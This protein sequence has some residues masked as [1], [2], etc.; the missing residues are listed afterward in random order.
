MDQGSKLDVDL[1]L[2][3]K[4]NMPGPRYTSYPTAPH[5]HDQFTHA[6]FEQEIITTNQ[7]EG[8]QPNLSLYFHLP[9]CDS[10]CFFC[11]CNVVI[12]HSRE[13]I[14]EYV[15]YL[16]KEIDLVSRHI[17]PS[18]KVVQLH[19]G[20]GTPTYLTP[21]QI[22][23]V[24]GHIKQRFNFAET[25]EISI[26]IDPRSVTPEHL[27]ALKDVG[28]NRLSF[29][30]QDV[31]DKVQKAVNR[32]QPEAMTRGVVEESRK[33]GFQS[34]NIDLMYGLPHQTIET[35]VDTLE[36]A[37]DISPDRLA[38]FNYAHVP[39]LK[40]HQNVLPAE[41]LPGATER[42]NI[43]KLVIERLTES[44]Y[45]YI[46][47]DHFA[48]PEDE[49]SL[50]LKNHTLY[51]NFQG[52]STS[53]DAE[54]YAM[55]STSISQ[56]NNV[57]A[58]NKKNLKEYY[59]RLDDGQLPTS[60]GYRLSDDDQV[61]RYVITEVM[62]NNRVLK[63]E[64]QRRFGVEFDT[65]FS[66]AL[67]KMKPFVDE[68]LVSLEPDRLQIHEAGRLIIRNIAMAFD[69]YLEA[70]QQKKEPMYSRTV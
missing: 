5:F 30:V 52:Y 1:A 58:Q 42:L 16:K 55:G 26:E 17:N 46:G 45:V 10:L 33:L 65:Y 47:M 69:A 31:D 22:R 2:L 9:F 34:I 62:C 29:G 25:A 44:G 18:R 13:R 11:A 68:K 37:I 24:F 7:S 36:T 50:A 61:R 3:Q 40:K 23:E 27:P 41:A 14:Q 39:W 4:Y 64:V 56:L 60:V 12:T 35:Y 43:L 32:I 57:Y 8:E 70:D 48:K 6:D 54:I 51:R 66:K 20:G 28:F 63:S 59:Q 21:D 67:E 53:A 19:W 15:Q 49:L 38:V